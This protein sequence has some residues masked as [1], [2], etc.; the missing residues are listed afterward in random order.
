MAVEAIWREVEAI[1]SPIVELLGATPLVDGP[2]ERSAPAR[3]SWTALWM[4]ADEGAPL[5][6]TTGHSLRRLAREGRSPV[7][8]RIASA[9]GGVRTRRG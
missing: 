2:Q 4:S 1:F 7:R 8:E 6:R 3:Q 5:L 9:P